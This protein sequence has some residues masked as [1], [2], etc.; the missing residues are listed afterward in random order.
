MTN[1]S[2]PIFVDANVA[3]YT[4]GAPSSFKTPCRRL[5]TAAANRPDAFV[6]DSEVL[7]EVLHVLRRRR[8]WEDARPTFLDFSNTMRTTVLPV[9]H[10]DLVRAAGF[11][12]GKRARVSTRDLIHAAVM[13]RHGIERVATADR[14]FDTF[15]ELIRLDPLALDEW[16]DPD[17]FPPGSAL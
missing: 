15:P 10:R 2:L 4:F 9:D 14:H 13:E 8:G 12:D 5:L 17:W 11:A 16:A 3:I 7:Q 1:A 6:T